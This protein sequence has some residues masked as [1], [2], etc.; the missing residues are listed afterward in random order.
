[1]PT[2]G[3]VWYCIPS[4]NPKR[5][6]EVT[7]AWRE[8][9]YRVAV[10]VDR[11][12]L[13]DF[14]WGED[15]PDLVVETYTY[16]GYYRSVNLLAAMLYHGPFWALENALDGRLAKKAPVGFTSEFVA[17]PGSSTIDGIPHV[18]GAPTLVSTLAAIA[19]GG[20]DIFP[21]E[22]QTASEIRD[23][24]YVLREDGWFVAQPIGDVVAMPGTDKI[25]G[26]PWFGRA[27]LE[28]GYSGRGPFCSDY[29]QFYG[30][31]E[32]FNVAKLTG[33]YVALPDVTQRHEHYHRPGGPSKLDYQARNET[34]YWSR[35]QR[36]F[37]ERQKKNWPG[38]KD[39]A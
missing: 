5:A 1:V 30:D 16:P 28:R 34:H 39:V 35:D 8:M 33:A 2:T 22:K 19:T 20:D 3:D 6:R 4:C 7:E 29:F 36:V 21:D 38:H 17:I 31:E 23:T 11:N 14:I 12:R 27:W 25:C 32:L 13:E 9:G 18:P 37:F 10:L 24:L 26:S 15:A